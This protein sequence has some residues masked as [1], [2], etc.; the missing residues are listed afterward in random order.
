[1]GNVIVGDVWLYNRAKTP[2]EVNWAIKENMPFLNSS[3]Y[4]KVS[5]IAI[6]N[7]ADSVSVKWFFIDKDKEKSLLQE[8]R[9]YFD[10]KI[11]AILKHG[12]KPG[13]S[14][15]AKQNGPLAKVIDNAEIY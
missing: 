12:S 7:N 4:S 13:W 15:N 3:E 5:D 9:V 6:L 8:V 10:G 14:I 2:E 11:V 1:M